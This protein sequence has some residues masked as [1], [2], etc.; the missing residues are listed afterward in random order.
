MQHNLF[1]YHTTDIEHYFAAARDHEGF[2]V[3]DCGDYF[4]ANYK[5]IMT[6]F[7]DIHIDT[8]NDLDMRIKVAAWN[9]RGTLFDKNGQ[10]I[11]LCLHKFHN[12]NERLENQFDA[13]DW[14]SFETFDKLDGSLVA[15]FILNG[16]I[17]WGT[18]AGITHMTD[19]IEAFISDK[20]K[21]NLFASDMI[22]MQYTPIFEFMAPQHRVVI[23][24]GP[25]PKMTLLAIRDMLSG[26]YLSYDEMIKIVA[27]YAIPL[28]RRWVI[29]DAKSL[30]NMVKDLKGAEGVV[31]RFPN[32]HRVKLKADDYCLLHKT[33]SSVEQE[34][35]V[36]QATLTETLDD[37]LPILPEHL[38]GKVEDYGRSFAKAVEEKNLHLFLTLQKAFHEAEGSRKS[39]ALNETLE[40]WMKT[41]GFKLWETMTANDLFIDDVEA[42]FKEMLIKLCDSSEKKFNEELKQKIFN[43]ELPE[44][45][46][47]KVKIDDN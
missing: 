27:S 42:S 16:V 34:R 4:L 26:Q 10:I 3:K 37:L 11:R 44:W 20:S 2:Y 19:D 30:I 39:F 29:N 8:G 23:D 41:I 5:S 9:S 36:A 32:D 17:R 14:S 24:Y 33:R 7:P 38:R 46:I 35:Y 15:P 47:F 18:K 13:L 6:K 21:Y 31:I 40:P 12:L 22:Q 1:K 28:V 25:E 45:D 43:K